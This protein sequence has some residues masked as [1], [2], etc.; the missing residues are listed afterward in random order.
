VLDFFTPDAD[1]SQKM[2]AVDWD[3]W[4]NKAGY[5]PKP[6]FDTSMVEAC[7]ALSDR[8]A[9]RA[10]LG[11][12]PRAADIAGWTAN[13]SV[14]FLERIQAFAKAPPLS[15][16]DFRLLGS[17]YGYAESANVELVSRY[18]SV[19]LMC[20]DAEVLQPTAK[21]LGNVGRMKFV[22]PLFKLLAQRDREFAVKVFEDNR[23]FYHPICRAMVERDLK[24]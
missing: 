18:L 16:E 6:N 17:V 15:V 9:D 22:R 8:W 1:A 21:L 10:A 14:V 20:G 2:H 11:F 24:V 23:N 13:Q 3:A 5:P 4:Y 19:G 7:Y 12:E